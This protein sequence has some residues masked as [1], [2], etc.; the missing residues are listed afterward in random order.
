VHLKALNERALPDVQTA[1][2]VVDVVRIY[3]FHWRI[4]VGYVLNEDNSFIRSV[5]SSNNFS[6]WNVISVFVPSL[7]DEP[8]KDKPPR[9]ENLFASLSF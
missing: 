7:G 3:Y 1:L 8:K 9:K 4:I 6:R 5:F 2:V